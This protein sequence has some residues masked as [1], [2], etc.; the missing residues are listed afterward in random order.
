M[1]YQ[2]ALF[3][4]YTPYLQWLS[5]Q[6]QQEDGTE[7]GERVRILPFSSCMEPAGTL[8]DGSRAEADDIYIF[9]NRDGRMEAHAP[10][11][12]ARAFARHP[13]AALVYADEDYFGTLRELYGIEEERFDASILER[14]QD[15]GTGLYRG[16]PWFKP[17]FSPD[18]LRSF[19]YIGGIF[20]IRGA[21]LRRVWQPE[22]SLYELV[23]A[24]A[25][26]AGFGRRM[27]IIHLP[28][29]LYTNLRL[30]D[31]GTL[32]GAGAL[33]E[34]T[35]LSAA[36][37]TVSV[38]IPSRNH[39]GVLERCLRT[40][41]AGTEAVSYELII[42]DNGSDAPERARLERLF[43]ELRESRAGLCLTYL[44]EESP[45][46]FSR[47]CNQGA[48]RA[49]GDYLLFLNDDIEV[50]RPDWLTN[51]LQSARQRHVGAVGAKLLYPD[52]EGG[53]ARYHTIQHVGITN[54]AIG[55]A[56]K[57]G[58]M[59]DKGC[60]Y[61]GHNLVTYDMLAVTAACLLIARDKFELAGGFDE[62]LAI[63]YNDVSL[64]FRLY[65][66]GLFNV[67]R[68]DAAL[69]H[70]ESL[71]RGQDTSPEKQ[72]RLKRELERLY[73]KHPQ[74]KGKDPF[75]SPHLVQWKKDVR[76]CTGYL[77]DCDRPVTPKRLSGRAVRALPREH[78]QPYVR[79]LTGESLVMLSIDDIVSDT[80]VVIT[81]W[82]A[83][84]R[85]DNALVDGRL[86][87][88][89]INNNS[90]VYVLPIH[91]QLRED[92]PE[93]FR[94]ETGRRRTIHMELSG[95]QVIFNRTDLPEGCYEV[96]I[97]IKKSRCYIKWSGQPV[98]CRRQ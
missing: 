45:F 81:G 5:E 41:T 29:V 39:S 10:A 80:Q 49:A 36:K 21:V 76:Y 71:S 12:I 34:K 73:K 83:L 87:L 97:L 20:A 32:A 24:I 9:I 46:N 7:T 15:A 13:E 58:G 57:L 70:H 55:P 11:E 66:N 64:C 89:D 19:F 98:E 63:A 86:L 31:S 48:R 14:Y 47:M 60:L 50:I 79:K 88:R 96:G 56:H 72:E 51:M 3:A 90:N 25:E 33:S 59:E 37:D 42:V 17:D 1:N 68:N 30:S 92:V 2:E 38:I 84:R 77:Y 53:A 69:Y 94:Q 75:Y 8:A 18:T 91:P 27:E 54:M 6:R 65:E 22:K 52:R 95:I 61:H 35:E 82:Y 43:D 85:H 4:Q 74:L 78:T 62:E 28:Q 26:L 93:L 40:L 44:Y 16:A 67:L 23:T